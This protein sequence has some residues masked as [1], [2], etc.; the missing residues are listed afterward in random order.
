MARHRWV[1]MPVFVILGLLFSI[2]DPAAV[3]QKMRLR[4]PGI[5]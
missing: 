4:V 1:I 5:T 2:G 3:Q